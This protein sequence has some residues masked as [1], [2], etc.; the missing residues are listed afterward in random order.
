[1]KQL[2]RV[3]QVLLSAVGI[4]GLFTVSSAT[5]DRMTS[6]SYILNGNAAGSFGGSISST[7]YKMNAIGGET[8]VG[9]GASSSYIIKQGSTLTVPTM[10]L[11]VQP[12]GL[13]AYYSLDEN[14]GTTTA[15]ASV[16]SN[17]GSFVSGPTWTTGK[18][19]SAVSFNGSN[20]QSVSVPDNTA[21]N[22]GS[23]MTLSLW[24]NQSS[25][26]L[27]KALAS[28]W[29]YTGGSV[30]GSWALQVSGDSTSRL[31]F[32]VADSQT[33]PGNN[34]AET[35]A[36]TWSTGGWHHITVVYDGTQSTA[37]NRVA[38]YIDGAA[39]STATAGTLPATLQD[40]A[41]PLMIG[42][43]TGLNRTWNGAID[44][45]KIFSRALSAAEVNAEYN[46]QNTGVA[47][48]L[49]LG[50]VTTSSTTSLVDA[51]VR[52]NASSYSL[53]VQQ[54]TNLQSGANTIAPV[55]G[56]I[57]APATWTEGTTKGLGFTLLGAP[58][59]DSKWGSGAKYAA[60]PTTATTFYS[61]SS[62]SPGVIDVINARL[63]LDIAGTQATG[64]Y[65]NNITYTGTTIP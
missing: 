44:H 59:L 40:A 24:A 54:D 1:M 7:S 65:S 56:T 53:S 30:S 10:Q 26:T 13:I 64:A 37:A 52:T 42:D 4:I 27:N 9:N 47:T 35:A 31:Q 57:A 29:N 61:T 14:S 63:K 55:S 50:T 60:F 15:D 11:S 21:L 28:H 6:P 34:Y 5:A 58:T 51:I 18:L 39:A 36:S 49:T 19:G 16:N 48:G 3:G 12:N 32:F 62:H 45:V 8:V 17:N 25:G 20:G 2:W 43:F 23:Q 22:T 38:I 33:D 41:S 46:A